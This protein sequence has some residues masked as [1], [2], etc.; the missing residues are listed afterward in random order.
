MC[1]QNAV[2]DPIQ[3]ITHLDPGRETI[4]EVCVR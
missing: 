3:M 2:G 1:T 4:G